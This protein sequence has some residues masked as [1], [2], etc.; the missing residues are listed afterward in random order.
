[1][2]AAYWV[3]AVLALVGVAAC[4]PSPAAVQQTVEAG[5]AQTQAAASTPTQV[6]TNTPEPTA[7]LFPIESLRPDIEPSLFQ[8][9]DLSN[10]WRS[11]RFTTAFPK[12]SNYESLPTPDLVVFQPVTNIGYSKQGHVFVA[13]YRDN[14]ALTSAYQSLFSGT[15]IDGFADSAKKLSEKEIGGWH[16]VAFVRCNSLVSVKIYGMSEDEII[17]IAKRIDGR[18]IKVLC[19]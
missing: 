13:V 19:K 3:A 5:V 18:L 16:D 2:K 1:M 12:D 15:S 6:A 4:G 17:D 14:S 10:N 7:T 11:G 8:E 9:G